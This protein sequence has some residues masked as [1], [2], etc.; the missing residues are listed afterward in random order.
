MVIYKDT[1][2]E[3]VWQGSGFHDRGSA[4]LSSIWCWNVSSSAQDL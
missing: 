2:E 3:E 1:K 4:L